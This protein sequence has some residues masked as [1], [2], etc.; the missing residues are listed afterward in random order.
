[1]SISDETITSAVPELGH[2]PHSVQNRADEGEAR[3]LIPCFASR[4]VFR[5]LSGAQA[6]EDVDS[7]RV[8]ELNKTEGRSAKKR[9]EKRVHS[10]ECLC[11]PHLLSPPPPGT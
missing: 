3:V 8:E 10:G 1:M 11:R 9:S 6:E 5:V 4:L 2:E 7:P